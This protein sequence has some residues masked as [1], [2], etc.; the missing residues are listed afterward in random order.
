M[1][2]EELVRALEY[3]GRSEGV[4]LGAVDVVSI[5]TAAARL[6]GMSAVVEAARKHR[7]ATAFG[8][9]PMA[10]NHTGAELDGALDALD[11]EGA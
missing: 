1:T 2:D 8:L 7:A 3:I 11:S 10:I 4:T 9:A 6:R 5:R